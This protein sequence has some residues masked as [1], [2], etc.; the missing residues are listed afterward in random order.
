MIRHTV[1][2]KTNLVGRRRITHETTE[3]TEITEARTLRREEMEV[4]D[5]DERNRITE[6]ITD[7]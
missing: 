3:G 5:L 4:I 1:R 7:T 6:R 2:G